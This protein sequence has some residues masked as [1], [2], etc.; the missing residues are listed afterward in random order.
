VTIQIGGELEILE[1][2]ESLGMSGVKRISGLGI[3]EPHRQI[4]F[5]PQTNRAPFKPIPISRFHAS[6]LPRNWENKVC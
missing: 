4:M 1:A 3:I 5:Q 2:N 6:M